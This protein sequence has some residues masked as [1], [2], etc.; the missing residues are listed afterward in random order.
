[1]NERMHILT[2]KVIEPVVKQAQAD[3]VQSKPL[4]GQFKLKISVTVVGVPLF[5]YEKHLIS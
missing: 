5:S 4:Q 2:I 3:S 1:M